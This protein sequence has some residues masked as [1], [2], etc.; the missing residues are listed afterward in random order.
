LRPES[1]PSNVA[2]M[3]DHSATASVETITSTSPKG[4]ASGLP[5]TA[6]TEPATVTSSDAKMAHEYDFGRPCGWRGAR[7]R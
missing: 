3:T 2:E 4:D 6:S 5:Y 1:G 7:G